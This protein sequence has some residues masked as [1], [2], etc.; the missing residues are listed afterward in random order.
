MEES[1]RPAPW[2]GKGLAGPEQVCSSSSPWDR[3]P[4]APAGLAPATVCP[5]AAASRLSSL[6]S[7]PGTGSCLCPPSP[8]APPVVPFFCP[9]SCFCPSALRP[10]QRACP[11]HVPCPEHWLWV[12]SPPSP[13]PLKA[14]P[15]ESRRRVKQ[16]TRGRPAGLSPAGTGTHTCGFHTC[17]L[18]PVGS[19]SLLLGEIQLRLSRPSGVPARTQGGPALEH[20]PLRPGKRVP[21]LSGQS[22]VSSRRREPRL[23]GPG[24]FSI[25]G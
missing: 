16:S 25:P 13:T 19:F 21:E 8:L 6:L 1:G 12:L 18:H 14:F 9:G 15:G 17:A 2:D 23:R 10:S 20:R 3:R 4:Q 11:R 22:L 24:P 5:V 7:A